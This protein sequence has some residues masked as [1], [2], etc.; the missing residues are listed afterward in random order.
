MRRLL[1]A[2]VCLW[3]MVL[4]AADVADL[5]LIQARAQLPTIDLW[6]DL[7]EAGLLKADQFNISVGSH[8]VG[9]AA[10]DSF[11]QTGEGVGYVFLVDVSKSLTP[12]QFSQ[13]KI[14]LEH[15]LDGMLPQDRAALI[16][17]GKEVK[18]L[19]SFTNDRAKLGSAISQLSSSDLETNLFRGVLEAIALGRQQSANLPERRAILVLSDGIDDTV[20]GV[21]VDEV[22][23]QNAE[24][25]VPI[26]SIGFAV[27]PLNDS[28][29]QGLKVLGMLARQSG[30]HFVQAEAGH[31]DV[32]YESQFEVI[33]R[34]FRLRLSCAECVADGQIY[35]LNLT[36][37]D[38][39]HSL[40]DGLDLRLLPQPEASK[41]PTGINI[42]T[43][44][45]Q[46]YFISLVTLV[47]GIL[48]LWL[49]RRR[50][51]LHFSD[52]MVFQSMSKSVGSGFAK[53]TDVSVLSA[54]QVG[55]KLG[56]TV[57]AGANKGQC[58]QLLI[59]SSVMIGRSPGCELCLAEDGEISA[60]HAVLRVL[61][62]RLMVRDLHS[63]NGTFV[64]GVPIHNEF[65]LR[66]GD[67]LLLG[68]TELRVELT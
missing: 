3:S 64:N 9:I 13:I 48:L 19:V 26:H 33:N 59:H 28:K 63:T 62:D 68:R 47:I 53:K 20:N 16:S 27:P 24:Y 41:A 12:Q 35:R 40:N 32:A 18:Q 50:E 2:C 1:L 29:R 57:V 42:Q 56:L 51:A 60:Q 66:S 6:L 11:R 37:G 39:R 52:D 7:P 8:Q 46:I 25:R 22:L 36:W 38:G 31:L 44:W 65:P 23:K 58:H 55:L 15:W 10:I 14:A 30:G 61:E 67:L 45:L 17:V 49:Y 21:S 4:Q 34:A 54:P 5:H 43:S